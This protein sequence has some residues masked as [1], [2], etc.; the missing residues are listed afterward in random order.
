MA[1]NQHHI[2]TKCTRLRASFPGPFQQFCRLQYGKHLATAMVALR[3]S[4]QVVSWHAWLASEHPEVGRWTRSGCVLIRTDFCASLTTAC[5]DTYLRRSIL[6]VH[7]CPTMVQQLQP[8][9][10][11]AP[12]IRYR[13][14][15][16]HCPQLVGWCYVGYLYSDWHMR[17]FSTFIGGRMCKISTKFN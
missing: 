6:L 7:T 11:A 1:I 16:M 9:L 5:N 14:L 2:L 3:H 15:T 8:S 13:S 12:A 10:P 17:K 4:L